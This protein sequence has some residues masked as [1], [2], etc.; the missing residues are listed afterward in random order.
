MCRPPGYDLN[1]INYGRRHMEC[2]YYYE[3]SPRPSVIVN[4]AQV[5][6]SDFFITEY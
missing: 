1:S 5:D 6:W 3:P 4:L 2:A